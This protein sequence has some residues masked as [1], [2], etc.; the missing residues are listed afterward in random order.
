MVYG[1]YATGTTTV[2]PE[3]SGCHRT[4]ICLVRFIID[5]WLLIQVTVYIIIQLGPGIVAIIKRATFDSDALLT[6]STV[7]QYVVKKTKIGL[8]YARGDS[9]DLVSEDLTILLIC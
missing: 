8:V 2:K 3:Y 1:Y 6:G 7:P 5:R 9:L 4:N